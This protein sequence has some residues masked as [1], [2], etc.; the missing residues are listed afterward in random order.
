MDLTTKPAPIF[1]LASDLHLDFADMNPE[2]FDWRGDVLILAGDIAED[3]YLRSAKVCDFWNRVSEMAP[4]IYV[5]TGNH[6]Y[7]H[8]EIDTADDHIRKHLENWPS[9]KLLQNEA[10]DYRGLM[11]FGST[12]WTSFRNSDPLVMFDAQNV[13]NDYKM[14]RVKQNGYGRL[15]PTHILGEHAVATNELRAALEDHPD[16]PFLVITHHAPT[17]DAVAPKYAG[18]MINFCY[19]NE[20]DRLIEATPQI[21]AWVHGHVH[22]YY[23]ANVHGCQVMCNPRGY[24]GERP[25]HLPP[26]QPLSF[27]LEGFPNA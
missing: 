3:D 22:W 25:A 2:F 15:R 5:V 11:I 24:P 4:H 20:F 6:E 10:I 9:I 7:Y 27:R 17:G 8:S 21:Q 16:K 19:H 18:D 13:M 1:G 14:I 12:M 26:Y 23:T